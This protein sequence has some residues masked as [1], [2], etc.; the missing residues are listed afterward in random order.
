MSD[1]AVFDGLVG[2][3]V[4]TEIVA[5]HVGSDFN[6]VPVLSGVNG[7][8]GSDHFGHDDSVTEVGL[9]GLGLVTE[10]C[11]LGGVLE[12]LGQLAVAFAETVLESAAL[13]GLEHGDDV[14]GAQFE[15]LFEFNTSVNLLS[16]RFFCTC[17]SSGLSLC[18]C[19]FLGCCGHLIL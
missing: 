4:F 19:E 2:H 5:D 18:C 1:L 13:A 17:C 16:E 8:N 7:S 3:G 10:L 15:Q 9:N 14:T 12:L 6:F 11:V